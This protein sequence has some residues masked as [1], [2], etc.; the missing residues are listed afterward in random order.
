MILFWGLLIWAI[1]A[2]VR[3]GSGGC[4]GMGRNH[5]HRHS[6]NKSNGDAVEIL[7]QRYAKGEISR[8]EFESMKKDLQ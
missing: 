2:L 8:E 4:C 6:G 7:K 1:V 5:G 3:G